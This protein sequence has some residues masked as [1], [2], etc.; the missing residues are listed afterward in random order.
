M[1]C[2]CGYNF[3]TQKHDDFTKVLAYATFSQ[4]AYALILDTLF[5]F[6]FSIIGGF[7][8]SDVESLAMIFFIIINEILFVSFLKGQTIGK[9]IL[10]IRVT[11]ETGQSPNIYKS[12]IR[13][14]C[15]LWVSGLL[16]G[17]GFWSMTSDKKSQTWHDK[18]AKTIVVKA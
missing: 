11:T 8:S 6:G 14:I 1:R 4:R 16:L 5:L 15:K 12:F 3:E 7:I 13:A 18:G 10:K 2:D 17:W 9:L